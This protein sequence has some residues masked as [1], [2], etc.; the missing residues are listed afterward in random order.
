[1][2]SDALANEKNKGVKRVGTVSLLK[3]IRYAL[4]LLKPYLLGMWC[5]LRMYACVGSD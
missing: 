1:M 3:Q 5:V 2:K 4:A